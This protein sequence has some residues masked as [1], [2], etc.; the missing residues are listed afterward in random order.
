M[1]TFPLTLAAVAAALALAAPSMAVPADVGN[2][3][4]IAN[5]VNA[6][7][8][9]VAAPDQ[10]VPNRD[11][12]LSEERIIPSPVNA[13]GT[14]VAAPDQQAPRVVAAPSGGGSDGTDPLPIVVILAAAGLG[15]AAL[16]TTARL[17]LRRR[18]PHPTA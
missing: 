10:Q 4:S 14:D 17:M 15:L 16:T 8:T 2:P 1:R 12:P 11:V 9:D 6:R 18:H 5:P 7:G 13:R 3:D